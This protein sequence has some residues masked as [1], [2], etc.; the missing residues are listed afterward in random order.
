MKKLVLFCFAACWFA[1]AS[2]QKVYFLYLQSDD[3]TPFYVKMGDKIHSSAASGYLILPNLTDGNY[4]FGLGFAKSSAAEATFSIV[5]NQNDKGYIIKNFN[6]G[7]ALFD[8][9]DLSLVKANS[10]QQDNKAFETKTDK[11]STVLSKAANDPGL[12]K[13]PVAKKEEPAK[14]KPAE[15]E[16]VITAKIEETKPVEQPSTDT[17][18]TQAQTTE[19]ARTEPPK[20]EPITATITTDTITTQTVAN[21]TK[22]PAVQPLQQ[23]KT[24]VVE[25][26]SSL[27]KPSVVSRYSESSTTE[28]FGV[29]YFDK[30]EEGTDTIRILIPSPKVKLVADTEMASAT[31]VQTKIDVI[32]APVEAKKKEVENS[33]K[34]N[35]S[36]TAAVNQS[37]CKSIASDKDFLKLRK[38]MASKDNNDAMLDEAR[39]EFRS[40]CYSVEQVRNLSTL[41]LTSASKYQFFDIAYYYV[42]DKNNFASLGS[43]IKDEHY[44]KRFKALI[45]E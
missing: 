12:L 28:G 3:Q 32:D 35:I 20:Q 6:D 10:S 37:N 38:K 43:E 15:K 41:F 14:P 24:E 23:E 19:T 21:E 31:E 40:K 13:V 1:M 11:F 7:L 17:A 22:G 44:T 34:E 18:N 16:P 4:T 30:K 9:Q 26:Q 42:S 5:I 27:Y 8:V 45:G 39:R 25:P 2:A 36:P 33:P 29:I